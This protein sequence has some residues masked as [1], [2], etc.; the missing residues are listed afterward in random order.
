[1]E[2]ITNG[3]QVQTMGEEDTKK[4]QSTIN[5]PTEVHHI[6][7]H[8]ILISLILINHLHSSLKKIQNTE[9]YT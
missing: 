6:P 1:M 7:L 8:D 4:R 5:Q 3:S 2:F 9:N